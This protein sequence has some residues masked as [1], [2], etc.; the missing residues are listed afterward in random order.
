MQ[1]KCVKFPSLINLILVRANMKSLLKSD[2]TWANLQS[3][4]D[5]SRIKPCNW[6]LN[7][8]WIKESATNLDK[9]AY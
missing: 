3:L 2:C 9:Y 6:T 7:N 4:V 8:L 5:N 1:Y